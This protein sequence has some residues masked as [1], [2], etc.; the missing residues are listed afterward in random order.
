[1]ISQVIFE[2]HVHFRFLLSEQ[3]LSCLGTGSI[4]AADPAK[5]GFA[6]WFQSKSREDSLFTTGVYLAL[7]L[8][9]STCFCLKDSVYGVS[10]LWLVP[11]LEAGKSPKAYRVVPDFLHL[12]A[13]QTAPDGVNKQSAQKTFVPI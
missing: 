10:C 8:F 7:S 12:S 6:R 9:A 1:M 13:P 3:I 11:L 5:S 2:F 4:S